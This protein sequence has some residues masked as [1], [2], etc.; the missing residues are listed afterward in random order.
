MKKNEINPFDLAREVKK[1]LCI[2]QQV[3]IKA[4]RSKL[5]DIDEQDII[6]TEGLTVR[7]IRAEFFAVENQDTKI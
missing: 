3:T 4:L 2:N 1:I 7:E 5:F 6:F